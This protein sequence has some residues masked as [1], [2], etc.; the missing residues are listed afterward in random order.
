M[1]I[2]AGAGKKMTRLG[3]LINGAGQ[4]FLIDKRTA[5]EFNITNV[6]QLKDPKI[7]KLFDTDGDGKANLVGCPPGWGCERSIEHLMDAY[8]LRDTVEHAQG[9]FEVIHTDSVSRYKAGER[10][11][12]Y[13]YTPQ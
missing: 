13:A 6:A 10:V 4:G 11:L 3:V 9:D 5:K 2:K 1:Y 8:K 12:Y 7:A